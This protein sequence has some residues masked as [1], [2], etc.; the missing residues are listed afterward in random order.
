MEAR[1]VDQY[2]KIR[3]FYRKRN[4]GERIGFG[5]VPAI[6]VI[7]FGLAWTDKS[8]ESPIGANLDEAVENTIKILRAARAMKPKPPIVFTIMSYND[9]FTDVA[10]VLL[11]KLPAIKELGEGSKWDKLDP[12]LERQPDEPWL[13]KKVYSCFWGTPLIDI[14][15]GN[16]ADTLIITG[17][18]TEACVRCTAIASMHHGFH[19]IIPYEAVG[20]RD[21]EAAG[22][23]LLDMD[24]RYA[25]VIST[26]ETIDYL[27]GLE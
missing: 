17:C 26:Q 13:R 3:D 11:K 14:L 20:S 21:P 23:A 10:P 8:G 5:K 12:R 9:T 24:L 7:D 2:P 16:G 22:W 4:Y 1:W 25:D 6:V 18:T 19:T 15:I 27:K